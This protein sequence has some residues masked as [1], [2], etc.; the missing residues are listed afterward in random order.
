MCHTT[1]RK[2]EFYFLGFVFSVEQSVDINA[3]EVLFV[4]AS[5]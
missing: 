5:Y 3:R 4:G 1:C 2:Q